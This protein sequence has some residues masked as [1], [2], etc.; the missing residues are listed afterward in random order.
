MEPALF[1]Q[2]NGVTCGID[3]RSLGHR[4]QLPKVTGV[5]RPIL[6]VAGQHLECD[7]VVNSRLAPG[8]P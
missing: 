8:A 2:A 6:V 3:I 5:L 7:K 1:N 4:K